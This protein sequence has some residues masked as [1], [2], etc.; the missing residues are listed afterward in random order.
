MS[1]KVILGTI[2]RGKVKIYTEKQMRYLHFQHIDHTHFV[3]DKNGKLVRK[4]RHG[5]NYE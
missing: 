2:K 5:E 3:Y 1:K 4:E